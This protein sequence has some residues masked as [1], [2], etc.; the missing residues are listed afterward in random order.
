MRER[1]EKRLQKERKKEDRRTA[2]LAKQQLKN[3]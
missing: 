1:K 3:N 2:R